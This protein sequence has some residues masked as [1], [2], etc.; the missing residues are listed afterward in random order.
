MNSIGDHV[1]LFLDPKLLLMC[2][3]TVNEFLI[4][5]QNW[6]G[7]C[8]INRSETN[9]SNAKYIDYQI[10]IRDIE[11]VFLSGIEVS[12]YVQKLVENDSTVDRGNTKPELTKWPGRRQTVEKHLEWNNS[13]HLVGDFVVS[14][15][16]G[17]S[18]TLKFSNI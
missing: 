1:N 18:K 15:K 8:V 10:I 12:G 17:T 6:N 11:H 3:I 5:L 2:E 14:W 16:L 7:N 13:L 4:G 9:F